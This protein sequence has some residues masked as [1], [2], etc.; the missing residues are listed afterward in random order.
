MANPAELM[1]ADRYLRRFIFE[2]RLSIAKLGYPRQAA[3]ASEMSRGTIGLPPP[4]E[5]DPYNEAIGKFYRTIATLDRTILE[6]YYT[7]AFKVRQFV[8]SI[9]KSV[10]AFYRRIRRLIADCAHWLS[11][12]GYL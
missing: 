12:E 2:E 4:T 10:G 7:P 3:F 9:G 6:G 5:L 8:R 1:M 11:S